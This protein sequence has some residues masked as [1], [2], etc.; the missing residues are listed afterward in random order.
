MSM[1]HR[2]SLNKQWP[3]TGLVVRK[4]E[5]KPVDFVVIVS[6][7]DYHPTWAC[8]QRLDYCKPFS[9]KNNSFLLAKRTHK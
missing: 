8:D 1:A 6:F 5:Q 2:Q 7:R 4:F 9:H 3:S